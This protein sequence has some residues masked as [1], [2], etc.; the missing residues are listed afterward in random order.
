MRRKVLAAILLQALLVPNAMTRPHVIIAKPPEG[1]QG[2]AGQTGTPAS[3]DWELRVQC[4]SPRDGIM[5]PTR[6]AGLIFSDLDGYADEIRPEIKVEDVQSSVFGVH[7]GLGEMRVPA[8]A[9]P[10]KRFEIACKRRAEGRPISE[11]R[12]WRRRALFGRV[13]LSGQE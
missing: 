8:N 6:M 10:T 13:N 11:I 5:S 7:Q 12:K 4:P 9:L 2:E 3:L 1:L